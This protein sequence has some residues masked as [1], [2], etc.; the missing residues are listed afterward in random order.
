MIRIALALAFFGVLSAGAFAQV[1]APK[2]GAPKPGAPKPE[3]E[4]QLRFEIDI[5]QGKLSI[6]VLGEKEVS[7]LDSALILAKRIGKALGDPASLT[8]KLS[9]ESEGF[10]YADINK[11]LRSVEEYV[12]QVTLEVPQEKREAL[13]QIGIKLENSETLVFGGWL[14]EYYAEQFP[15][16]SVLMMWADFAR[17]CREGRPYLAA[18]LLIAM[19][20]L[21]NSKGSDTPYAIKPKGFELDEAALQGLMGMVLDKDLSIEMRRVLSTRISKLRERRLIDFLFRVTALPGEPLW[22]RCCGILALMRFRHED[23]ILSGG[24]WIHSPGDDAEAEARHKDLVDDYAE[25][26]AKTKPSWPKQLEHRSQR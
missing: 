24:M 6:R 21:K 14:T 26:W 20:E 4:A 3:T 13:D 1:D 18:N 17:A 19:P 12:Y 10:A 23:D 5:D 25:W 7:D 2:P 9:K 15:D 22:L 16:R 11:I 8:I